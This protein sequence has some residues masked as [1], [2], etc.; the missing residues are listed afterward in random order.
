MD[1]SKKTQDTLFSPEFIYSEDC[2]EVSFRVDFYSR[3]DFIAKFQSI[4]ND[5]IGEF[6]ERLLT[7]EEGQRIDVNSVAANLENSTNE[8]MDKKAFI[9]RWADDST[10]NDWEI[11]QVIVSPYFIFVYCRGGQERINSIVTRF[12]L[13]ASYLPSLAEV[14]SMV[15]MRF[16]SRFLLYAESNYFPFMRLHF[17]DPEKFSNTSQSHKT[18]F[19]ECDE[20][21]N[22]VI[23][24]ITS[25]LKYVKVEDTSEIIGNVSLSGHS[26]SEIKCP[27]KEC[28]VAEFGKLINVTE[29]Y[30]GICAE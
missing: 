7:D 28:L 24:K 26:Y 20:N 13:I 21:G 14:I 17:Y 8:I 19:N 27:A 16:S 22:L 23:T 15:G 1:N 12:N 4:A 3:K 18:I 29:K 6:S 10:E 9:F 2:S 25:S 5:I 11:T 30:I